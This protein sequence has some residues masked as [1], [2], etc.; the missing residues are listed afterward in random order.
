MRVIVALQKSLPLLPEIQR[1]T[2]SLGRGEIIVPAGHRA[3]FRHHCLG[4]AVDVS[5]CE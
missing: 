1:T 2:T 5:V 4:N 3:L